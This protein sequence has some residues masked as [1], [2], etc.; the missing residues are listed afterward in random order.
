MHTFR[1]IINTGAVPGILRSKQKVEVLATLTR[2][3]KL[4]RTK[5]PASVL[6]S[7]GMQRSSEF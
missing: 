6:N 4:E 7:V 2:H 3:W 1:L 5:T